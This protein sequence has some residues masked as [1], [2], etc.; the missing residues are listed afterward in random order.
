[1]RRGKRGRYNQG[2][3][4]QDRYNQKNDYYQGNNTQ[5]NQSYSTQNHQES[6][7]QKNYPQQDDYN[8]SQNIPYD[9]YIEPQDSYGNNF[10]RQSGNPFGNNS[11]NNNKYKKREYN[12]K[13]EILSQQNEGEQ[14]NQ[15]QQYKGNKPSKEFKYPPNRLYANYK[16]DFNENFEKIQNQKY[17]QNNPISQNN[18]L[19]IKTNTIPSNTLIKEEKKEINETEEKLLEDYDSD[20]ENDKE[21]LKKAMDRA[22]I[23]ESQLLNSITNKKEILF[24]ENHDRNIIYKIVEK[25][26]KLVSN[27]EILANILET[28]QSPKNDAEIQEDLV[29]LMG[30][31]D[32]ETISEFIT[33]RK[34]VNELAQAAKI[35][36]EGNSKVKRNMDSQFGINNNPSSA[37]N[38]EVISAKNK[39]KKKFDKVDFN[40]TQT[41][42]L[43]ILKQLGFDKIML[44]ENQLLG[45]HEKP[46][47]STVTKKYGGSTSSSVGTNPS[48]FLTN[49]KKDK[50]K[51]ETIVKPILLDK[52]PVP[53]VL[54]QS[55]PEWAQ[56]NIYIKLAC[57]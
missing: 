23:N 22:E 3:N 37:V 6:G 57:F 9:N 16:F 49:V 5:N 21:E 41:T 45:L 51:V 12:K 28:L 47:S 20:D 50:T 38:L 54:V 7:T 14:I 29:D 46:I 53:K 27:I 13:Q 33:N 8:N 43:Q 31:D 25:N 1:M 40:K 48:H 11:Y 34:E 52:K 24:S 55:L 42:N 39:N 2:N 10:S 44:R 36:I 56:V 4:N 19:P 15:Q 18:T 32:I 30:Y 26:L 35:V 17:A